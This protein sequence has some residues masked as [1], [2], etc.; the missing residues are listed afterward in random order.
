[1]HA[2]S[3]PVT[4]VGETLSRSDRIPHCPV[5]PVY[6]VSRSDKIAFDTDFSACRTRQ[7]V[8]MGRFITIKP[9]ESHVRVL[10]NI[11]RRALA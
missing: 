9:A 1:M 11:S 7:T 4:V 2:S 6:R 5:H 8:I 3:I 10:A